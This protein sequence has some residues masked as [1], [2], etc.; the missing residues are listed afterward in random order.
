MNK[1]ITN[2]NITKYFSAIL[3]YMQKVL[4]SFR[5]CGTNKVKGKFNSHRERVKKIQKKVFCHCFRSGIAL[6]IY[7]WRISSQMLVQLM[8]ST[9]D[10]YFLCEIKKATWIKYTL[11]NAI[12]FSLKR[13]QKQRHA[14]FSMISGNVQSESLG[15]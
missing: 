7:F 2:R 4:Q 13:K 12:D 1:N 5:D 11:C 10:L 15:M 3:L 9:M 6:K 8:E 14:C